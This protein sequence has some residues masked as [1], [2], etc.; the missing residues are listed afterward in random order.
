MTCQKSAG[1]QKSYLVQ[2]F[3][4]HH[5]YLYRITKVFTYVYWYFYYN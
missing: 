4:L 5:Y 1:L 3:E 2:E